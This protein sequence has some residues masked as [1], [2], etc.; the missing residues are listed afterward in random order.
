MPA[1]EL[2]PPNKVDRRASIKMTIARKDPTVVAVVSAYNPPSDLVGR[3]RKLSAQVSHIVVVDDGSPNADVGTWRK[4]SM[5]GADVLHHSENRGIAAALNTGVN[6]AFAFQPDAWILTMDQDSELTDGYIANALTTFRQVSAQGLKVGL[7]APGKHNGFPVKMLKTRRGLVEA[8]DPMQSGCL[9]PGAVIR[10][11]GPL[12][13]S[14]FIDGVDTD[15]N[16]RLRVLGYSL[17]A[18][19]GSDLH[20]E[21]GKPNYVVLFKRVIHFRGRP[22]ALTYHTPLRV[23]YITRN[24]FVIG[25][26]YLRYSPVWMLQRLWME[27]ESN[28]VRLAFGP[29]RRA[30][31]LAWKYGI[32]DALRRQ[33]GKVD[34]E[35]AMRLS[36]GWPQEDTSH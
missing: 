24:S 13:E 4:L 21:L 27:V 14:L 28:L 5:A 3:V 22:L 8:F 30:Y 26:R 25:R 18:S 23:Y 2:Y 31:A 15:F 17:P 20:H 33:L 29:N 32:R 7:V 1:P 10:D 35:K 12:D 34:R 36:S 11:A 9:V 19:I 6:A 16:A